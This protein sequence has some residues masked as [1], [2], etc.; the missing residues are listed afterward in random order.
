MRV[1][2]PEVHACTVVREQLEEP[3]LFF[4][5]VGPRIERQSTGLVA[6]VITH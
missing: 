6:N 1:N 2:V 4:H 3:V 5:C